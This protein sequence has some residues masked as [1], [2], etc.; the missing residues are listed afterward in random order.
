MK[1][2][3]FVLL[4][5][6]LWKCGPDEE[7]CVF[8]PEVSEENITLKVEHFEDSLAGIGTKK[9]LIAFLTRQ[10]L[11][12]DEML[13]RAEYPDD[14]VFINEMFRRFNNPGIDTLLDETKR[15]FG[16]GSR[17]ESEFRRAFANLQYYYPDFTP[18]KIKTVITGL[19]TDLFV[20][21]TL[22]LVSLDFFLGPDARYRPK[23][24]DYLMRRYDPDDI[25]PSCLLI[26]GIS[27]R[28]NKT[29]LQDRTVLADMIAYGKSFYF[30]KHMIPC[31]PDSVLI[32]YTGAEIRGARENE[33]LIWARFV[34]DKI[35]FSTNVIDKK[36][37]LGDRPVTIQV[38]EKCPGRIG[39][40]V[41]WN[42]VREYMDKHPETTL[43]E[44]MSI[45]NARNL[46]KD[47]GYKPKKR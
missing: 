16:D 39:Q 41:G 15:V 2:L 22:I 7:P 20:S 3:L 40:W 1:K 13:R 30:A 8:V 28:F 44:L 24:Y 34:E 38:G 14:S 35:L 18:P 37:Y 46:F 25:V 9:K 27:E 10:P 17:L 47:S 43:P 6:V 33:D 21:D 23:T 31:T 42:I 32:W 29:D 19:D 12:R 26:Y 11:I 5:L 4:A 36:N 45:K